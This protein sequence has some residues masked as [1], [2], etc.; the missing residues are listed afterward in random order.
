MPFLPFRFIG[1][2]VSV[3]DFGDAVDFGDEGLERTGD[4]NLCE[5]F[6]VGR[7]VDDCGVPACGLG[8]AKMKGVDVKFENS[9][10][11]VSSQRKTHGPATL[12]DQFIAA[13]EFGEKGQSGLNALLRRHFR[14]GFHLFLL[15][16]SAMNRRCGSRKQDTTI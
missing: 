15:S 13:I 5:D 2:S 6:A 14:G 3:E 11:A 12:S 7:R 4:E 1:V 16:F 10:G 9:E 8:Q